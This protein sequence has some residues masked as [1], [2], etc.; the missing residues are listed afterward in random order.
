[1]RLVGAGVGGWQLPG[2]LRGQH[3]GRRA[4]GET[5]CHG[6]LG[7]HVCAGSRTSRVC[8]CAESPRPCTRVCSG[9]NPRR[10]GCLPPG[11]PASGGD[12]IPAGPG[13]SSRCTPA[14]PPTHRDSWSPPRPARASCHPSSSPKGSCSRK[15]SRW[16]AQGSPRCHPRGAQ[17]LGRG[18]LSPAAGAA[19]LGPA[20]HVPEPA[21]TPRAGPTGL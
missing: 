2:K 7:T 12:G 13:H 15:P 4:A 19:S 10:P 9:W 14:R 3:P 1:M 17:V 11:Q 18:G 16:V 8:E 21:L 20:P 6:V 5:G